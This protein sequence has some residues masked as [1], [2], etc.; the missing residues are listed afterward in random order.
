[1]EADAYLQ[2]HDNREFG[3]RCAVPGKQIT[4]P[5]TAAEVITVGC[6]DFND[7]FDEPPQPYGFRN[8]EGLEVPLRLRALS[9]YSNRGP[10]RGPGGSLKPDLV[11]PGRY[12]TACA[13]AG[14]PE[15][16]RDR[17]GK[18]QQFDGT[19]ASTAYTAGV[20]ALLL[21]KRPTL[22]APRIKELLQSRAT[23]DKY[24]NA[25][26]N[27][28]PNEW[29]AAYGHGKLTLNAVLDMLEVLDNLPK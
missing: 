25:V 21:Q 5:G 28:R 20:V 10:C 13:P 27:A 14:V 9:N 17:S 22:T 24:T 15:L 23:R 18:Y 8:T 2:P 6:Y 16:R 3:K 11:A 26:K 29:N 4:S 1:M 7:R 12:F 19:S